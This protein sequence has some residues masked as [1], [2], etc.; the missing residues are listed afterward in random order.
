MEPTRDYAK[1]T[2]AALV[3]KSRKKRRSAP[4]PP[5]SA[6]IKKQYWDLV[7]SYEEN[8]EWQR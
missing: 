7:R 5:T 4:P 3:E 1:E 2:M 8:R 6:S